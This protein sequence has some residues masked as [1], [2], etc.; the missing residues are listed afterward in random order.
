MGNTAVIGSPSGWFSFAEETTPVVLRLHSVR[1]TRAVT[2]VV[3]L[4]SSRSEVA[5]VRLSSPAQFAVGGKSLVWVK[6]YDRPQSDSLTASRHLGEVV[7]PVEHI[8][9]RCGGCLLHT[10]L[11]LAR[12]SDPLVEGYAGGPEAASDIFDQGV[13]SAAR[14]PVRMPIVCLSLCQGDDQIVP[15]DIHNCPTR[16][17]EQRAVL[18]Y[19]LAQ[20]HS[21]HYRLLQSLY[22]QHRA[23]MHAKQ[24]ESAISKGAP[25]QGCAGSQDGPGQGSQPVCED[26]ARL[27]SEIDST[28]SEANV[29]I[30]QAN[31]AIRILKDRLADQKEEL[32]RMLEE[33]AKI[34]R[35]TDLVEAECHEAGKNGASASGLASAAKGS[36]EDCDELRI[37]RREADVLGEQKEALLLILDDLYGA[38]KQGKGQQQSHDGSKRAASPQPHVTTPPPAFYSDFD[39][40]PVSN[41][42]GGDQLEPETWTNMLPRP[43]ELF[44]SGALDD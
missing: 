35:E 26:I 6:F 19:G 12:E 29:R 39:L 31:D 27:R 23:E 17:P 11:P 5:R 21:Q 28:T 25:L 15:E 3:S 18:F 33:T 42:G 7:L 14:D 40:C 41:R 8:L 38:V 13:R 43:S 16:S 34:N 20:S 1:N 32:A 44:G 10:W 4:G 9:R 24:S 36:N 22:R 37:L 30:S 2:G